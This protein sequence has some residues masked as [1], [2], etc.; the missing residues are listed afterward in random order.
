MKLE[1]TTGVTLSIGL[2]ILFGAGYQAID[3][4]VSSSTE[5]Q[6]EDIVAAESHA[7]A[8]GGKI[9]WRDFS[10]KYRGVTRA[11]LRNPIIRAGQ[12]STDEMAQKSAMNVLASI[13]D[14]VNGR[15]QAAL[16]D[17][18]GK[19]VSST[20]ATSGEQEFAFGDFQSVKD[21]LGGADML[22]A[23]EQAGQLNLVA[24]A[25]VSAGGVLL[26]AIVITAPVDSRELSTWAL[27]LRPETGLLFVS[28]SGDNKATSLLSVPD[29]M[30]TK[31]IKPGKVSLNNTEYWSHREAVLDDSGV[32]GHVIGL[33]AMSR[34]KGLD[35]VGKVR[36]LVWLFGAVSVLMTL[37]VSMFTPSSS[38]AQ[39]APAQQPVVSENV[40]S[41]TSSGMAHQANSQPSQPSVSDDLP[42]LR[43]GQGDDDA[44]E[45]V[46]PQLGLA[47]EMAAAATQT[48]SSV[49]SSAPSEMSSRPIEEIPTPE[50]AGDVTMGKGASPRPD[51]INNMMNPQPKAA[52]PEPAPPPPPVNLP[53]SA[54]NASSSPSSVS[55][56]PGAFGVNSMSPEENQNNSD[57]PSPPVRESDDFPAPADFSNDQG[58]GDL[59]GNANLGFTPNFGGA[60]IGF[61]SE[62]SSSQEN[63]PSSGIGLPAF[64]EISAS[65]QTPDLPSLGGE[66]SPPVPP[67]PPLDAWTAPDPAESGPPS[68]PEPSSSPMSFTGVFGSMDKEAEDGQEPSN[69]FGSDSDNVVPQH[70]SLPPP[71]PLSGLPA[72]IGDGAA[73]LLT[74]P[75]STPPL[76]SLSESSPAS[77]EEEG[78][79]QLATPN[80]PTN[81]AD[82]AP[83]EDHYQAVFD[84]FVSSKR[85]LGENVDSITFDGFAA[86]LRK[87]E[88]KLI[89]QHGC[90]AVRFEVLVKGDKVSLRPQLVR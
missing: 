16:L 25:P 67:M 40:H 51:V 90:K 34:E 60:G 14:S 44:E 3:Q 53:V 86:K 64:E 46:S 84:N 37:L 30:K 1:L 71:P 63:A 62:N 19:V 28:S 73:T 12:W 52:K 24:S 43:L 66:A 39:P 77:A 45:P 85:E 23:E 88:Q 5:S 22:R 55:A 78:T 76:P 32:A 47:A 74:S 87:S 36:N 17:A 57:L 89:D 42:P 61:G 59:G 79:Q 69:D 49:P 72:G 58:V 10:E 41:S 80:E 8:L 68:P 18:D 11:A 35:F 21:A 38:S 4:V 54:E 13:L 26:G 27:K 33:R 70:S 81:D 6:L 83:S 15:G 48:A 20:V 82:A 31:I 9:A 65:A 56:E 2:L 29:A 7:T 75:S 50:N